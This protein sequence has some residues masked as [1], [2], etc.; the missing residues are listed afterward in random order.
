MFNFGFIVCGNLTGYSTLKFDIEN[1][2]FE[3]TYAPTITF[4]KRI[5]VSLSE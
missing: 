3:I 5:T 4:A 2:T 1:P